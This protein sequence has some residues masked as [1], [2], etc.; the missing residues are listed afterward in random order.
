MGY[1][2][3]AD[4]RRALLGHVGLGH[5]KPEARLDVERPV[6]HRVADPLQIGEP[7]DVNVLLSLRAAI[8]HVPT[9]LDEFQS[10]PRGTE[11]Q[12]EGLPIGK[13]REGDQ[14]ESAADPGAAQIVKRSQVLQVCFS[15]R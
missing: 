5:E 10:L 7:E 8:R 2:A 14:V 9:D 1:G 4:H 12:A 3:L 13:V 11:L 6:R 15:R